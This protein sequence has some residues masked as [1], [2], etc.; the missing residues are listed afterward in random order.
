MKP[1]SVLRLF[2]T[3]ATLA[4]FAAS[5]APAVAVQPAIDE[6]TT[7]EAGPSAVGISVNPHRLQTSPHAPGPIQVREVP[8]QFPVDAATFG[9]LKARANAAAAAASHLPAPPSAAVVEK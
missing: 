3:A 2:A 7:G 9:S 1:T 6:T 5:Y 8:R 4:V